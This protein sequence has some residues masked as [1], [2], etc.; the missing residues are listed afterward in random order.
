[1]EDGGRD[2][3]DVLRGRE[4]F[5]YQRAAIQSALKIYMYKKKRVNAMLQSTIIKKYI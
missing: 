5:Y 2:I 1:M 3:K 4:D